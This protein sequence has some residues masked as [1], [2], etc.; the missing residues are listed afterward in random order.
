MIQLLLSSKEKNE[1]AGKDFNLIHHVAHGFST[2]GIPH[3]ELVSIGTVGFTRALNS[4]KK[5]NPREAKFSTYCIYCI[6]NE[7]LH[8]LRKEKKYKENTVL[9]GNPMYTDGEGNSLTI[10]DTLSNEKVDE[11]LIEDMIIFQED[12]S[13]LMDAISK[14]EEREQVIIISRYGLNGEKI[15]TQEKIGKKLGMTQANISKLEWGIIEK[16]HKALDGK[17]NIE[18]DGFYLDYEEKYSEE[19]KTEDNEEISTE[20]IEEKDK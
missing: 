17:I 1:I 15:L 18:S 9:S 13:I 7:I 12:L 2:T 3:D 14:L 6:K 10:E 20:N 11:N 5:D 16:L 19:I 4:Y 8:F